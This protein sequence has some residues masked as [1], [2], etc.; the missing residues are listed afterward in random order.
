MFFWIFFLLG[1]VFA[2]DDL[3]AE[4]DLDHDI[5]NVE[6]VPLE[7]IE[8]N[9]AADPL[10]EEQPEIV[11]PEQYNAPRLNLT[12]FPDTR[13]FVTDKKFPIHI[14][15]TNTAEQNITNVV[16]YDTVPEYLKIVGDA[17][18]TLLVDVIQPGETVNFTYEVIPIQSGV[19]IFEGCSVNFTYNFV[20]QHQELQP[21]GQIYVVEHKG[22][23]AVTIEWAVCII[24]FLVVYLIYVIHRTRVQK[25][26]EK[27]LRAQ[28]I[29]NNKK[30]NKQQKKESADKKKK[31]E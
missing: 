20:R 28:G 14:Q 24:L 31:S 23:I 29:F 7:A 25:E 18:S 6:E 22:F 4:Q 15:L 27:K 16:I 1:L 12:K 17:N 13:E 10:N 19:Q 26:T 11:T 21:L 8:P 30:D 3:E 5:E 2:Q 9:E